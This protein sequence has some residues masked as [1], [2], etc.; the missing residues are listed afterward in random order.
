MYVQQ[1][2]PHGIML[3]SALPQ[4]SA[5]LHARAPLPSHNPQG[6]ICC[7]SGGIFLY[8]MLIWFAGCSCRYFFPPDITA[9]FR[10]DPFLVSNPE[11][12]YYRRRI[13]FSSGRNSGILSLRWCRLWK[14]APPY[15][16]QEQNPFWGK[17][18]PFVDVL[19]GL[20]LLVL[21]GVCFCG[22]VFLWGDMSAFRRQLMSSQIRSLVRL[23]FNTR[24]L[25]VLASLV[26]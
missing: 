24:R 17:T 3:L 8:G 13:F 9:F 20:F 1:F 26:P 2:C 21:G 18:K 16:P 14:I 7:A 5:R 19:S 11:W 10:T 22:A 12:K 4:P 6:R 23:V 15:I 25:P